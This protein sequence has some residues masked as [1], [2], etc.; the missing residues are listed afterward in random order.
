MYSMYLLFC[1]YLRIYLHVN[2]LEWR[3][4]GDQFHSLCNTLPDDCQLTI[5]KLKTM[6]QLKGDGKEQL[7][8]LISSTDITKINANIIT[9]VIIKLCY[10]GSNMNLSRVCDVM[11]KLID[12]TKTSTCVQQIRCG[13]LNAHP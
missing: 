5:D 12:S 9:Y 11:E 3:V 7:S 10:N 8:K 4:L 2:V 6:P 13:K 1:I